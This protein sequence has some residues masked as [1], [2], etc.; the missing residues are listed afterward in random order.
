MTRIFAET[1]GILAQT[2]RISSHRRAKPTKTHRRPAASPARP[3]G[4]VVAS[5]LEEHSQFLHSFRLIG[6]AVFL[7]GEVRRQV[8]ELRPALLLAGVRGELPVPLAN[9]QRP[10]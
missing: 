10:A 9:G 2:M 6:G 3:R 4:G 8:K 5:L 7:F 1:G